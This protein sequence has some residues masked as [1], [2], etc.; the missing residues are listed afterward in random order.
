MA[1]NDQYNDEYQFADLDAISPD[2]DDQNQEGNAGAS[3]NPPE[4]PRENNIKRNAI[5]V[6]G[7]VVLLMVLYKIIGMFHTEKKDTDIINPPPVQ[8]VFPTQPSVPSQP[9]TPVS[10]STPS[11]SDTK[12]AQKLSD[13]ETNQ[14]TTLTEVTAVNNQLGGINN[15]VNAMSAKMAEL[16]GLVA[17]LTAKLEEQSRALE[18]IIIRREAKTVQRHVPHKARP[19][20]PKYNLQAVIPGRAWLI[21]TN[22]AT[23]TVR[24]GT[25]IAGYG[26]VKLI[27]PNQGRVT[28]S[29][30]QVI[31]FSQED[32]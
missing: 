8:T 7:V 21:A 4:T 29:S 27:D 15:N 30:G 11:M 16:T 3:E 14:Q 10:Q 32:S 31:K 17:S 5:I 13:L 1:D 18:Q 24:E 22:G 12:V 26:I 6:I 2:G 23:L 19:H 25:V 9:V 28:T 20:Y